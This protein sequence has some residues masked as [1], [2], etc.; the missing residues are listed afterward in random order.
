MLDKNKVFKV[1]VIEN[2]GDN[3]MI[4]DFGV[5]SDDNRY[6]LTTNQVHTSELYQLGDV[7]EQA[8]LVCR[9]LNEY[10]ANKLQ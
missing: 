8:E 7:K 1:D 2:V 4:A 10:Y 3:W 9:L 5:D 6:I